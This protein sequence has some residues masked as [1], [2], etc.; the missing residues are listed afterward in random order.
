[1][2][3]GDHTMGSNQSANNHLAPKGERDLTLQEEPGSS[4]TDIAFSIREN[5]KIF[6]D[7]GLSHTKEMHFIVVRD[8]LQHFQHLHPTRD[9][10]GIWHVDFKPEAGG[11]YWLYADF[12]DTDNGTYTIPYEKNFTGEKG[13]YGLVENFEQMKTID[14]YAIALKSSTTG[15]DISFAYTVTDAQGNRVELE[16]YLGAKG[17]SVLLSPSK[18]FIHTHPSDQ[19]DAPVF[20]TALPP[21]RFYRIFTQFQIQGKVVTVN[22]DWQQ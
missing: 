19:S 1:M 11:T 21:H 2:N 22:F 3:A 13:Q 12:V 20:T 17:H 10:Q 15:K 9:A 4:Q 16:E 18:D 14:G 7:F 8:D 5:E 6:A